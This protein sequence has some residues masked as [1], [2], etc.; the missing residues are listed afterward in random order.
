MTDLNKRQL[1][2]AFGEAGSE[3]AGALAA[4]VGRIPEWLQEASGPERERRHDWVKGQFD[5]FLSALSPAVLVRATEA[6]DSFHSA[7]ALHGALARRRAAVHIAAASEAL[8]CRF[9]AEVPTESPVDQDIREQW[10]QGFLRAVFATGVRAGPQGEQAT[11]LTRLLA[12]SPKWLLEQL[13]DRI[14]SLEMF[15][16]YAPALALSLVSSPTAR[17]AFAA[18]LAT[19]DVE[20][21][22]RLFR[23]GVAATSTGQSDLIPKLIAQ[24][25]LEPGSNSTI[26]RPEDFADAIATESDDT[27]RLFGAYLS[28]RPTNH[29]D[30]FDLLSYHTELDEALSPLPEWLGFGFTMSMHSSMRLNRGAESKRVK[31]TFDKATA[32]SRV[33]P[34]A[35]AWLVEQQRDPVY[36]LDYLARLLRGPAFDDDFLRLTLAKPLLRERLRAAPATDGMATRVYDR[37]ERLAHR[38]LRLADLHREVA[39]TLVSRFRAEDFG[40]DRIRFGTSEVT[41]AFREEVRRRLKSHPSIGEWV[42]LLEALQTPW[43][44]EDAERDQTLSELD[45]SPCALPSSPTEEEVTSWVY[46]LTRLHSTFPEVVAR[47]LAALGVSAL[48]AIYQSLQAFN[49]S[50]WQVESRLLVLGDIVRHWHSHEP[51]AVAAAMSEPVLLHRDFWLLMRTGLG[52]AGVTLNPPSFVGETAPERWLDLDV[53]WEGEEQLIAVYLASILRHAPAVRNPENHDTA[54]LASAST[55]IVALL[56]RHDTPVP[57]FVWPALAERVKDAKS[58]GREE[59]SAVL[60]AVLIFP[61]CPPRLELLQGGIAITRELAPCVDETTSGYHYATLKQWSCTQPPESGLNLN[62]R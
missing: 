55:F 49:G 42:L 24:I 21:H 1:V 12:S 45:L 51:A 16:N 28:A 7:A 50:S 19:R 53:L 41:A 2:A 57:A 20:Q 31:C 46:A 58:L 4:L 23:S 38:H 27:A 60:M 44:F 5:S 48:R 35:A 18:A 6:A 29:E 13:L 26:L 30:A 22:W 32:L 34:E 9:A 54:D 3:G 39:P 8:T 25:E 33:D 59:V 62:S 47:A 61:D 17:E 43:L 40:I 36:A 37:L 10:T 15:N 14:G 56:N 11:R 52:F